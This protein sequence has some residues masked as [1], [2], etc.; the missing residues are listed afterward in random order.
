MS[1]YHHGGILVFP[2]YRSYP[3][4]PDTVKVL[5][6][7]RAPSGFSGPD[8][9]TSYRLADACPTCGTGASQIGPLHLTLFKKAARGHVFLTLDD[10]VLVS[11]DLVAWIRDAALDVRFGQVV[12]KRARPR[13]DIMQLLPDAALPPWSSRTSGFVV[14]RQCPSCRRDGFFDAVDVPL[15]L[16]YDVADRPAGAANVLTTWEHFG[17]SRLRTPLSQSVFAAPHIIVADPLARV[18]ATADPRGVE[19]ADVVAGSGTS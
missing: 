15:R 9:G 2:W 5:F 16:H 7:R 13:H 8:A 4:V 18:L 14:E 1:C 11:V 12:D 3:A 10:A 19:F 17:N 6:V